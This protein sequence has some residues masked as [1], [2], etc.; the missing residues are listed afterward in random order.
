[1]TARTSEFCVAEAA[2]EEATGPAIRQTSAI[3]AARRSVFKTIS[4]SL[5][6]RG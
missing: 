2:W 5:R 3:Q 6:L 4:L 1:M